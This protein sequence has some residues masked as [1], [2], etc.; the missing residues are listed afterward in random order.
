MSSS[1]ANIPLHF[2]HS[3]IA[4]V[5]INYAVPFLLS[6]VVWFFNGAWN[7]LCICNYIAFP[8][9]I[10]VT[11]LSVCLCVSVLR[12]VLCSLLLMSM[13]L[14]VLGPLGPTSHVRWCPHGAPCLH[15]NSALGSTTVT[16][17]KDSG[18]SLVREA[19]FWAWP[20]PFRFPFQNLM[21]PAD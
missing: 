16:G 21:P 2:I 9:A 12:C 1:L 15:C 19:Q 7:Y 5:T 10:W 6:V 17:T 8:K 4:W 13:I 3:A 18:A 20:C 11:F 14:S